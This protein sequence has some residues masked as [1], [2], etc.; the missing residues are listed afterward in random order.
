MEK[1]VHLICVQF[2]ANTILHFTFYK[3]SG[4]FILIH[5]AYVAASS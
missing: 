3:K 1:Y 4:R 5:T 2:E